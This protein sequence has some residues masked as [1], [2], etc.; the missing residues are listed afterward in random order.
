MPGPSGHS[1][2]DSSLLGRPYHALPWVKPDEIVDEG[3]GTAQD[4]LGQIDE[5]SLVPQAAE[6]GADF[7]DETSLPWTYRDKRA[8][9][10][11]DEALAMYP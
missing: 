6:A 3:E 4:V 8:Y 2:A 11:T 1:Q 10:L 9:V 5:E 7:H